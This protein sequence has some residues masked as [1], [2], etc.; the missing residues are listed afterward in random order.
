MQYDKCHKPGIHLCSESVR[1]GRLPGRL[2]KGE[3]TSP[4][5]SVDV[6]DCITGRWFGRVFEVEEIVQAAPWSVRSGEREGLA[7]RLTGF[8]V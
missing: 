7:T 3:G 5:S 2:R 4:T 6:E 1:G 8:S